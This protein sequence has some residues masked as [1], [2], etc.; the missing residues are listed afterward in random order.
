MLNFY[1][2]N[3]SDAVKLLEHL[4][5]TKFHIFIL[6]IWQSWAK[7]NDWFWGYRCCTSIKTNN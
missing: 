2:N 5:D 3:D 4:A 7:Q 6:T 1:E